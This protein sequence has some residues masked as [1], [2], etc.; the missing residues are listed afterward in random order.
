MYFV[1]LNKVKNQ[2]IFRQIQRTTKI[3]NYFPPQMQLRK[4][5]INNKK[6]IIKRLI[7]YLLKFII[8]CFKHRRCV[9]FV[10]MELPPIPFL[11]PEV[12]TVDNRV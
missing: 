1:I 9:P 10:A 5:I 7:N 2:E 3:R 6:M 11:V 8:N 4:K 12:R